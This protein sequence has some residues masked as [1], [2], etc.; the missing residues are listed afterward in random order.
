[1][2]DYFDGIRSQVQAVH[3]VAEQA[4]SKGLDPELHVEI[5]IAEDVAARVEGMV[6]PPGIAARIRELE[7]KHL[8]RDKICFLLA[9]EIARDTDFQ[10]TI[11]KKAEQ[12]LRTSLALMTESITAGPI[13]GIAKVKVR[14]GSNNTK[15]LAV[16][17]AGPIRSAGGTAAGVSVLLADEIR[18]VLGLD[19]YE[20]TNEEVERT[21]EEIALYKK[22][23]NLQLPS[24]PE[25]VRFA[26]ERMPIEITGEPTNKDEVAGYRDLPRIETNR[27][28]GGA[29]LVLNDGLV[30]RAQ[31]ICKRALNHELNDWAFLAEIPSIGSDQKTDKNGSSPKAKTGDGQNASIKSKRSD[32]MKP[33]DGYLRD[34]IAGRP[35]FCHASRIGGWRLRYGRSRATGLAGIGVHPACMAV[36]DDFLACGTHVRTERPGKGS[37]VMPVDTLEPPVVLLKTKEVKRF[38]TYD[39]AKNQR[40]LIEKVLFLG[41]MLVGFGEFVQNNH[42]IF[43]SG[44]CEEWWAAE[45]QE[46]L[47]AAAMSENTSDPEDAELV[48]RINEIL[49]KPMITRPT[50]EQAIKASLLLGVPLH[51]WFTYHWHDLTPEEIIQLREHVKHTIDKERTSIDSLT[52]IKQILETLCIPH[53]QS[54]GRIKSKEHFAVLLMCLGLSD[55][56]N[57]S[58]NEVSDEV[59]RLINDGESKYVN[60]ELDREAD[61]NEPMEVINLLSPV[62][63]MAKVPHYVGARMGR[64]EKAK[65]RSMKP[66]VHGLF[67]IGEDG[68]RLRDLFV[69]ADRQGVTVEIVDRHCAKCNI[70][71]HSLLCHECGGQTTF[72][73][74]CKICGIDLKEDTCSRCS[75]PAVNY[76]T[77]AVH[78]QTLLE[79]ARAK[80]GKFPAKVKMVKGLMNPRKIP[81]A[82][83]KGILRAK[84]NIFVYRDGTSRFDSTDVALTHFTPREIGVSPTRLK[85]LGYHSDVNG[86]PLTQPDQMLE[87]RVLDIV[88]NNEGGEYLL[89]VA[90]FMDEL[91]EFVYNIE[92]YYNASDPMDLVGSIVVGLAPHTSAGITGRLIGYTKAKIGFAHPYWHAAKRRNCLAAEEQ[93]RIWDER[94]QRIVLRSIEDLVEKEIRNGA[95][96]EIVDDFGTLQIQNTQNHLRVVSLNTHTQQTLLQPIKHWIKGTSSHWIKATTRTGRTIV[97]TPGHGVLLWDAENGRYENTKAVHIQSGDLIPTPTRL[98]FSEPYLSSQSMTCVCLH[99]PQLLHDSQRLSIKNAGDVVTFDEVILVE[100]ISFSAS[101]YCLETDRAEYQAETYH[102]FSTAN[103][104]TRNCDGDEDSVI[105]GLD[106]MLNFSRHFLPSTRGGFMDAPLVLVTTLNPM[107]VDDEAHQ[108]DVAWKYPLEFFEQSLTYPEPKEIIG[109]MD[110][111]AGRLEHTSAYEGFGYTHETSRLV[112]GA[113]Q[114]AYKTLGAMNEKVQAQL[115]LAAKLKPVDLQDVARKVIQS[116]FIPD[117]AGNMRKFGAQRFRCISCNTKYRRVPLKGVCTKCN[118]K[119]LKTIAQKSVSKYLGISMRMIEKHDLGDYL[120]DR[121]AVLELSMDSMFSDDRIKKINL[122]DFLAPSNDSQ[123]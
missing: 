115:K 98:T 67:P 70:L 20:A 100:H 82:L 25:Q 118:G 103:C 48:K 35:I 36:V 4:R 122:S 121:L 72:E 108:V 43:A 76:S 94:E 107:E 101:S 114:T 23:V 13:E 123:K 97:M 31:K 80:I 78:L 95:Q 29:C 33:K 47:T 15:Y 86:N 56:S 102:N 85:E 68:G 89:R 11:E 54:K 24:L 71:T 22:V 27:L 83:E 49:A 65:H 109:Y 74:H 60:Q 99:A 61:L 116:H 26:A 34:V 10:G 119:I 39:D 75:R 41:D 112:D 92:P 84:H 73:R 46:I 16:Y 105:L 104:I 66:P 30:G 91:L 42:T 38:E 40:A 110:L 120:K 57:Q 12:A 55:H 117:L 88:L 81:E 21:L 93:L 1:M 32:V 52:E 9:R 17:Y 7:A 111:V 44:Y 19:R 69:A 5:P 96:Q 2:R 87:L 63:I 113:E 50:V 90:R 77:R 53:V 59:A 58:H 3:D 62:E 28:R 37:I 106:A 79:S 51:P 14:P 64:P 8:P 18:K 6:G 45:L